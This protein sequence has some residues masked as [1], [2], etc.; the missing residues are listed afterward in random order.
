[1]PF[2]TGAQAGMSYIVESVYGT[3]PTP[4]PVMK[5]VPFTSLTPE[6]A[7]EGF[8]SG[9]IRSD[10]QIQDFRHGFKSTSFAMEVEM[11]HGTFDDFLSSALMG[12]WTTNVLKAGVVRTGLSA[13]VRYT[14]IGRYHLYNGLLVNSFSMGVSTDAIV[15]GSFGMVGLDMVASGTS[16]DPSPDAIP[17]KRSFDSFSGTVLEGGGASAIITSIEFS[18]ENALEPSKVIGQSVAAGFFDG[19]S[20]VTGT[21]S[22]YF[23]DDSLLN[24]FLNET[25]SSVQFTLTDPDANTL[26]VLIPRIIYTG[27]SAPVSAE[28][29]IVIALPFQAIY[30][31]TELTNIKITRSA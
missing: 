28:G 10:R 29:G 30:D 14:D 1:M 20:N 31:P 13:E 2:A 22:A 8:Q 24:K 4:T 11:M 7:K 9:V 3:T 16:V 15:T 25:P 23:E 5:S 21:V 6:V 27:G 18:L 17:A 26:T 12:T 19:R